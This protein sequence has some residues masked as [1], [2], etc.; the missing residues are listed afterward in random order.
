MEDSSRTPEYI[1]THAYS[2]ATVGSTEPTYVINQPSMYT[3]FTSCQYCIFNL[4]GWKKSICKC[5]HA[6]QTHIVQGSTTVYWNSHTH[7]FTHDLRQNWIV[8][9]DTIWP[10]KSEICTVWPFT[11]KFAS[12]WSRPA[13]HL[14][15]AEVAF[16]IFCWFGFYERFPLIALLSPAL[17]LL[18]FKCSL[19]AS[20]K[21]D[22][23]W[24][25][26]FR[27][28]PGIHDTFLLRSSSTAMV[29]AQSSG[30]C[31]R[32]MSLSHRF[33]ETHT[34]PYIDQQI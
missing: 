15:E 10:A 13:T 27:S 20:Y 25:T 12:P 1:K 17:T 8:G 6:V 29:A 2:S 14:I 30:Q 31:A 16:F 26:V 32:H 19:G 7:S 18:A 21:L 22:D 23:I 9:T 28:A 11:E 4:H 3:G 33:Q 24:A 5:S 34:Q